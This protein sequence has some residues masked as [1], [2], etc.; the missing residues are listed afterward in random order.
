MI[1]RVTVILSKDGVHKP[2]EIVQRKVFT[3]SIIPDTP[4]V[5]EVGAEKTPVP[6]T[7]VQNPVPTIGVLA[8]KVAVSLHTI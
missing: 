1:R 6:A 5:G 7:T 8:A 2:L 3:P 4:V